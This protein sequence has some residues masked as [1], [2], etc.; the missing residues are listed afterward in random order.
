MQ[1]SFTSSKLSRPYLKKNQFSCAYCTLRQLQSTGVV[2][3]SGG[4]NTMEMV[5]IFRLLNFSNYCIHF[6][7][8]LSLESFFIQIFFAAYSLPQKKSSKTCSQT[9][10]LF[11]KQNSNSFYLSNAHRFLFFH[12]PP[13]ALKSVSLFLF[14]RQAAFF[15]LNLLCTHKPNLK[16]L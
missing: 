5:G 10:T 13:F 6:S 8:I 12:Q 4:G 14:L 16:V 11:F 9:L 3:G 15:G 7:L 1:V 2:N